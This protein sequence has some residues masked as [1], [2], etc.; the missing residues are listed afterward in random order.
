MKKVLF[1]AACALALSSTL[2]V[3]QMSQPQGGGTT[4][5]TG[6]PSMANQGQTGMGGSQMGMR[7]G[8]M[9]KSKAMMRR[10]RMMHRRMHS[11]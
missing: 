9:M 8:R 6:N 4:G 10:H 5:P 1:A 3:A 7:S 2:A 11:M